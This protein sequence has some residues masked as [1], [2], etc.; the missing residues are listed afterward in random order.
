MLTKGNAGLL[1][2]H[3]TRTTQVRVPKRLLGADLLA[4]QADSGLTFSKAQVDAYGITELAV[5][6]E[7][8]RHSDYQTMQAVAA[9]IRQ[10]IGWIGSEPDLDFL[11]AY[12]AALRGRL[13]TQLLFGRRRK[14]KFD[15]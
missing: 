3:G 15:V 7:V 2:K 5:L 4:R 14:D 8:L 6:E 9:R 1:L 11:N 12:Y 10:K 13:E